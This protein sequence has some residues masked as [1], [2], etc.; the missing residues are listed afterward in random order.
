MIMSNHIHII[1]QPHFGF[2]PSDIQGS[3][4]KHTSKQLKT[5]LVKNDLTTLETYKVNKYDCDYQ[6]WKRN[7]LSI[8]LRTASVFN[9][10]LNYIHQNPVMAGLCSNQ[11]NFIIHQL[12]FITMVLTNLIC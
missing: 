3:F 6:V 10:K 9:Q 2:T 7:P 1:W 8:E 5:S 4:M 11:K 12:A